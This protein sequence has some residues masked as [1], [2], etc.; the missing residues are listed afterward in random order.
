MA[1]ECCI[2]SSPWL[3][4]RVYG[5]AFLTQ[6]RLGFLGRTP[7]LS[8]S[9]DGAPVNTGADRTATTRLPLA[10][11]FSGGKD[12][13]CTICF[14][15]FQAGDVAT[16]LPCGHWFHAGPL[17]EQASFLGQAAATAACPGVKQWLAAHASSCPNCKAKLTP[18]GHPTPLQLPVPQP[19]RPQR[20]APPQPQRRAAAA[21]AEGSE[22]GSI[23]E[24]NSEGSYKDTNEGVSKEGNKKSSSKDVRHD[25]VEEGKE[26][27]EKE[28]G[29]E[30]GGG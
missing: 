25:G 27:D 16:R 20:Q 17:K 6:I 12:R 13:T 9:L 3:V 4:A 8:T 15:E 23:K 19:A 22:Q 24:K 18:S 28:V 26:G 14:D 29:K 7:P 30:A 21:A 10:Q 1:A 2:R 5:F 11:C